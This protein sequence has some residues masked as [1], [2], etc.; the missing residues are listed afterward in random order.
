MKFC[1]INSVNESFFTPFLPPGLEEMRR[2]KRCLSYGM[3]DDEEVVGAA[4]LFVNGAV[5]EVRSLEYGQDVSP[6]LCESELAGF[7]TQ[8]DWDVYRIEY[9]VGGNGAYFEQYDLTMMEAGF[10]PSVGDVKRFHATIGHIIRHQGDFLRKFLKKKRG[11]EFVLGRNLTQRQIDSYNE[12]Y[13]YN[14]FYPDDSN[15]DY[16][17]FV[18]RHDRPI[19]GITLRMNENRQ[20]EFQWMDARGMRVMELMKLIVFATANAVTKCPVGT[21]VIICPFEREV[22]ALISKFGFAECEEK[23]ETRIYSYYL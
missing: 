15:I 14:R 5:I 1:E 7:I 22:E 8:Q 13:P 10:V 11:N 19:A 20:L 6:G 4:V 23:I 21:D 12:L 2:D 17:V 18:V 3:F 9:C 16:S